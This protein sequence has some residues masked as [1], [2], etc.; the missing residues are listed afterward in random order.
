MPFEWYKGKKVFPYGHYWTL[1]NMAKW[2][3]DIIN[4]G[5]NSLIGDY[6]EPCIKCQIKD[7]CD[8][9]FPEEQKGFLGWLKEFLLD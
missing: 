1:K 5:K 7:K 9:G 2:R 3:K 4:K 6:A 8:A